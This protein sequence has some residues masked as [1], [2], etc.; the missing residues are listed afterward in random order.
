M[1]CLNY[2]QQLIS[3]IKTETFVSLQTWGVEVHSELKLH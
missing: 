3:W 1:Q 2:K